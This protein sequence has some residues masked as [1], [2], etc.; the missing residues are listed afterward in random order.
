MKV[1]WT[2]SALGD[3]QAIETSIARHS[4]QYSLVVVERI[5]TK[6]ESLETYPRLGPVVVELADDLVRELFEDPYRIV[7]RIGDDQIDI[8]T[9]IHGARR[10]PRGL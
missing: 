3:L 9:V 4:P 5:F 8:L 10:I 2:E 7:Y 1:H 6:S